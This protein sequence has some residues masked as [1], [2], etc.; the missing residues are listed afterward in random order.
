MESRLVAE[1][2]AFTLADGIGAGSIL[3]KWKEAPLTAGDDYVNGTR[4]DLIVAHNAEVPGEILQPGAGW[5]PV[6]RTKVD[7]ARAVPG[8]VDHRAG[9]GRLR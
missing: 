8:I 6:L 9:A 3:K 2:N 4:T 5:T 7:P 1:H